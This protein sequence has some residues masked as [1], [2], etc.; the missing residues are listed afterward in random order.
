V[1]GGNAASQDVLGLIDYL[2]ENVLQRLGVELE[3][4]VDIW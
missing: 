1:A 2:R 3:T 4:A